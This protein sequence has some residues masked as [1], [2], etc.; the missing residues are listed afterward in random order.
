MECIEPVEEKLAIPVKFEKQTE[1]VELPPVISEA[2]QF[3]ND[4][5][6]AEEMQLIT[7]E[8]EDLL[9]HDPSVPVRPLTLSADAI[10][11]HEGENLFER[12][13]YIPLR[14]SSEER[15]LYTIL[16]GSLEISE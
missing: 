13:K 12:S 7:E 10:Q 4:E 6:E 14:F 5:Q 1:K 2:V 3:H 15:T 11:I 8:N 9:D 16:E